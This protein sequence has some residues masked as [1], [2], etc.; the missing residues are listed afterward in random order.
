MKGNMTIVLNHLSKEE[1]SRNLGLSL[2]SISYALRF[3]SN[4]LLAMRV[5]HLAMNCCKGFF[6][7]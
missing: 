7:R 2:T 5:R 6:L 4:S 1:I 3:K